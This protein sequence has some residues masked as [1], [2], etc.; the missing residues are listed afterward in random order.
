[1]SFVSSGVAPRKAVT[2]VLTPGLRSDVA[3]KGI[4]NQAV[5]PPAMRTAPMANRQ[6]N[7]AA[8]RVPLIGHGSFR[9]TGLVPRPLI[10]RFRGKSDPAK[11][12]NLIMKDG[13]IYKNA[14]N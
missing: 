13:K 5:Y 2:A 7:V 9:A 10:S 12:F 1:M 11:N 3:T 4:I 6:R 8:A 14:A